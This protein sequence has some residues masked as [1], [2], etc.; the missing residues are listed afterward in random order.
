MKLIPQWKKWWKRHSVQLIALMPIVTILREQLP[1][2][3][4]YL[5]PDV[6]GYTMAALGITA[7]IVMQIKQSAVSGEQQ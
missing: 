3:R 7:I 4:E 2:I 1:G 5:P 6:Y